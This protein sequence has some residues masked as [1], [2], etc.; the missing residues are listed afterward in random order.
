[1]MRIGHRI[2]RSLSAA[3]AISLAAL[4][5]SCGAQGSGGGSQAA[6]GKAQPSDQSAEG[7]GADPRAAFESS[8]L[9]SGLSADIEAAKILRPSRG[10]PRAGVALAYGAP[11]TGAV[12]AGSVSSRDAGGKA[13]FSD[14]LF[15][16]TGSAMTALPGPALAL[17]APG[18]SIVVS[19]SASG[20]K[21]F[22]LGYRP[23]DSGGGFAESWRREVKPRGR[24]MPAPGGRFASGG[25]DGALTMNDSTDGRELW[26]AVLDG[27][28]ADFAYAPGAVIAAAGS[29]LSAYDEGT[30]K[31]LWAAALGDAAVSVSAG[32]G[33]VAVLTRSGSLEAFVLAD[34]ASLCKAAGPFDPSVRAI[35]DSGRVIAAL[36]RGGAREL[37]L[38]AGGTLRSWDWDGPSSFISADADYL[39]AGASGASGPRIVVAPRSGAGQPSEIPL[40][41]AAFDAPAAAHGS[42]G[43]LLLLLQDG[44]IAL[45]TAAAAASSAPSAL[46]AAA[47]PPEPAASAIAAALGRF[48]TRNPADPASKYLRFDMFL[49]GVPVDASAAFTAYR[50][51][52]KASGRATFSAKPAAQGAVV[53]AYDEQGAELEA[54]VDELGSRAGVDVR[55]QKGKVYWIVAGRARAAETESFRLFLK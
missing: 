44:S 30:G 14:E 24:L 5:A 16:A 17:A 37:E 53:A 15:S 11:V 40:P 46:D 31:R 25:E 8:G 3:S 9:L 4:L 29:S 38:K 10:A 27:P 22:L 35:A 21:G 20:G 33:V 34:G 39:Y 36:P 42:R 52:A 12:A 41:A 7:Q 54:S 1:M 19:C 13:V 55:L 18:E 47:S 48:R 23:D 51:E 28:V 26:R 32:A 45:A 6:P 2:R 49:S 43:G 50:Y